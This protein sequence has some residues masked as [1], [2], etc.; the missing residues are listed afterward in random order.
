MK[1]MLT[2]DEMLSFATRFQIEE[3][4]SIEKRGASSW[5]VKV[6]DTSVLDKDLNRLYEPMPSNRTEE[7][8][9]STRFTLDEAFEIATAYVL[10]EK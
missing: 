8:I 5:C 3:D 7:F 6:F 10:K 1:Q 9:S 2:S 4:V